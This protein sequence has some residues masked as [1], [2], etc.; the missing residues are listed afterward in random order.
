MDIDVEHGG[1]RSRLTPASPESSSTE[2]K[3]SSQPSSRCS[4]P[5][6]PG[7]SV[8]GA[9]QSLAEQMRQIAL[10]SEGRP[11]ASLCPSHHLGPRAA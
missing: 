5:S 10:E 2:E 1:K 7:G 11:E 8:E 4:G 6:Q 9:T 3:N